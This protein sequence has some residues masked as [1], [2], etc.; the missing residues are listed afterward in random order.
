MHQ[1]RSSRRLRTRRRAYLPGLSGWGR[2]V[3][4]AVLA[5][6][7]AVAVTATAV[8]AGLP[9][10]E[11]VGGTAPG[12]GLRA[13]AP[14][15]PW[16]GAAAGET[17]AAQP[18][19]W[20]DGLRARWLAAL[21]QGRELRL[22]L[23]PRP[24]RAQE[25]VEG[26]RRHGGRV[27]W[28]GGASEALV[29]SVPATAVP[30]LLPWVAALQADG[31]AAVAVPSTAPAPVDP[32]DRP[33]PF[34][35]ALHRANQDAVGAT[36]LRTARGLT[37]RGVTV[38]V[39][40][41]GVDP[42]LAPLQPVGGPRGKIVDYV[43]L[44]SPVPFGQRAAGA[45]E[46][47]G[48]AVEGGRRPAWAAE[49]DVFL[50]AAGRAGGAEMRSDGATA[51]RLRWDGLE[52]WLPAAAAGRPVHL[53]W[54]D[55][56]QAGPTGADLDGS[57]TATERWLVAAFPA[58]PSG[59]AGKA[60]GQGRSV[61][62]PAAVA[63]GAVGQGG[64]RRAEDGIHRE[65]SLARPGTDPAA[66]RP[67]TA[68]APPRAGAAGTAVAVAPTR[69]SI[70][71][72][73]STTSAAAGTADGV[74]PARDPA[75]GAGTMDGPGITDRRAGD[76]AP[77]SAEAATL[78]VVVDADGDLD[79][80]EEPVLRP[81]TQGGGVARLAPPAADGKRPASAGSSA[82]AGG[83]R[84][85]ALV[86][87]A[88][89]PQGRL[90]NFGFDAHGHGTRMAS[91]LAARGAAYQGVAPDVRL[92][93]LKALDGRGQGDWSQIL[94]AVDHAIAH[95]ADVISLSAESTAPVEQL[96][97]TERLLRQAMAR[98]VLPVLAAGNGGPGLHTA[99]PLPAD[100][101]LVVGA[102]LPEAAAALLGDA[103]GQRPLPYSAAGPAA[104]GTPAPSLVG[105]GV[106]YALVPSGEAHRWPAG[107][108]PDEGTSVAVPYVAGLAALLLEAGRREAPG[109]T[110]ARLGPILQATARP[111]AGVPATVQGFGRPDGLRAAAMLATAG[112]GSSGWSV[113]WVHRGRPY[114]G[115]FWDGVP[116]GVLH[117]VV[118]HQGARPIE[119][120]WAGVPPWASFPG[121]MPYPGGQGLYLPVAYRLPDRPGLYD[122]LVRLHGGEGPPLGVLQ[123]F[124]RPHRLEGGHLEVEG[125]VAPGQ[126]ERV[127]V[128]VPPGITRLAF[129]V[130]G[131]GEGAAS[132]AVDGPGPE[133]VAQEAGSL[134]AWVFAPGGARVR[135]SAG[136]VGRLIGGR[137]LPAWT[138]S[139]PSPAP[140]VW[141]VDLSF[142]TLSPAAAA[143]DPMGF[144]V[145]VT[146]EGVRWHPAALELAAS[147]GGG[148]LWQP[149]VVE[150]LGRA[151][152]GRVAGLG[153][154]TASP[155]PADPADPAAAAAVPPVEERA[156]VTVQAGEPEPHR[157][158]VAEGTALLA[159]EVGPPPRSGWRPR[160]YLY[161]LD[162][163]AAE[164]VGDGGGT[165][166]TV[167]EPAPGRYYAVVELE[168]AGVAPPGEEAEGVG[169]SAEPMAI[170]LVVRRFTADGSLR[171]PAGSMDL[172]AGE[173]TRLVAS[174]DV[175]PGSREP[176]GYLVLLDEGGGVA[177]SLPVHV[178][179]GPPRLVVTAVSPPPGGGEGGGITLV[180]RD[181]TDGR[182]RDASL[183]VDGRLYT[184]AG[185]Q[186]TV[187]WDGRAGTLTVRVLGGQEESVQH[188][189]L[190]GRLP[191][192]GAASPPGRR[193]GRGAASAGSRGASPKHQRE[194][195]DHRWRS[196]STPRR[197][198][199]SG[200]PRR[201][202]W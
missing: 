12:A 166:V 142:S 22:I 187:P 72:L 38:A 60:A 51:V 28:A 94:A 69:D 43:D 62:A 176:T 146:A 170:P 2:R 42:G 8:G 141:E 137:Q 169:A 4:H 138:V 98:G 33:L 172:A 186:V 83:A 20:S 126:V 59:G 47:A 39:I 189:D 106:T 144:R 159:V 61:A 195:A 81:L 88:V 100:A 163:G 155:G 89:D 130:E 185:G 78:A 17:A 37:G 160:L 148:R 125:A 54:L 32:G 132:T 111:L 177:G 48:P 56:A 113:Q 191:P 86:V 122:A 165:A 183:V 91:I 5:V 134:S 50:R 116:P 36:A 21:E 121:P 23:W 25:L 171:V 153:W 196:S 101:G 167:V 123:A 179:R 139:V 107:L 143:G 112:A 161:R 114:R 128:E 175:P 90:V 149:V 66:G 80:A 84:G 63:A 24:G 193:S 96:P 71:S 188:L 105:P 11:G 92:L 76:A 45:A 40:D 77:T 147:A 58:P 110:A 74:G 192:P 19:G 202:A 82:A 52:L 14:G 131:V 99:L 68:A 181:R 136:D 6:V 180:V 145:T 174:V 133:G 9:P 201:G 154:A 75:T 157:L 115:I 109:L 150:A 18:A 26:V 119:G 194:G 102:Y 57:G 46:A 85:A 30:I 34:E 16:G 104:D 140:G 158:Q 135:D 15:D 31:P 156:R 7:L 87:T 162:G 120:R 3:G 124:V 164:P 29:A 199:R 1:V 55:E 53:G 178:R 35:L 10:R 67:D 151:V 27:V 93:V 173:A 44:T 97:V 197:S 73:P 200:G 129:R 70:T 65:S 13:R 127:F 95:G 168:A 152:R 184:T 190:P 41:T 182:W 108:A 64:S 117:L 79:L 198:T 49:G 118:R 103:A